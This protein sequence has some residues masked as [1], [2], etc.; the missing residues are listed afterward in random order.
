MVKIV[1][2]SNNT[3]NSK[4][5]SSLSA[6]RFFKKIA[7]IQFRPSSQK[8][9]SNFTKIQK[10][11]PQKTEI[12]STRDLY[13]LLEILSQ[14]ISLRHGHNSV[15]IKDVKTAITFYYHLSHC[16]A[17][18]PIIN[19]DFSVLF[20][21]NSQDKDNSI[22][23]LEI[24]TPATQQ[25]ELVKDKFNKM[26]EEKSNEL[27]KQLNS[28]MLLLSGFKA[29]N[30][31]ITRKDIDESYKLLR[32]LLLRTPILEFDTIYDYFR[33]INSDI[34][35]KMNLI[36]ITEE[37]LV[38]LKNIIHLFADHKNSKSKIFPN[39][40]LLK[41]GVNKFP[42]STLIKNIAQIY[43]L[44]NNIFAIDSEHLKKVIN[45]YEQILKRFQ[46]YKPHQEVTKEKL[47]EIY[48]K[49]FNLQIS[50]KTQNFLFRFR[51]NFTISM[52]ELVGRK[53]M[54]FNF[55]ALTSQMFTSIV[56]ISALCASR[57]NHEEILLE[58]IKHAIRIYTS[59]LLD[60]DLKDKLF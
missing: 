17:I 14:T 12:I 19:G 41:L 16:P 24:S 23:K 15:E 6:P 4:Y 44:K 11:I 39:E 56:V 50:P 36:R 10:S 2:Y 51:R 43:G 60:F 32:V 45:I 34:Y 25:L 33:L 58:D 3:F 1:N 53:E 40:K 42:I 46:F 49:K 29:K 31:K 55:S 21:T 54:L 47:L 8:V 7:S 30:N 35:K 20:K 38:N 37:G 57:F 48:S 18:S 26:L 9:L 13:S 5:A 28:C 59:L 27:I 52:N 22:K